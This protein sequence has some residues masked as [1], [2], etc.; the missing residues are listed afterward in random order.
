MQPDLLQAKEQC[1][2]TYRS[3]LEAANSMELKG[4]SYT[5]TV[6]R[7]KNGELEFI[8]SDVRPHHA[9]K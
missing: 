5:P 8:K 7:L 9:D 6:K 2:R 3:F 1:D 4:Y